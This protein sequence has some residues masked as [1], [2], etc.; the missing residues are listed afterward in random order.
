MAF[1]TIEVSFLQR[2]VAERPLVRASGAAATFFCDNHGLGVCIRR[3]IEYQDKHFAAAERLLRLHDLPV[4]PLGPYSTRAD[5]AQ[6]GGLSEKNYS[7][8]PH[9]NSV[10]VKVLGTCY[11][12]GQRLYTPV[13][14]NLVL[15]REQSLL[16]TCKRI[17][18]VENLESFRFL[19]EYSWVN[20]SNVNFLVVYRG[21]KHAPLGD[22]ASVLMNRSEP[23]WA[24]MDFDPAGLAMANALPLGRLEKILLPSPDWIEVAANTARGRELFDT[25]E[26]QYS[27][28]LD[29]SSSPQVK[30]AWTL[31]KR[32]KSGVTQERMRHYQYSNLAKDANS[33]IEQPPI[34]ARQTC[35]T[36]STPTPPQSA[37]CQP[38]PSG[39]SKC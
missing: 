15:T 36:N 5:V 33:T 18:L 7:T 34:N 1:T 4:S 26:A 10:N 24:F 17:M 12:D 22:A 23:I 37:P 6:F 2:L 16:V 14:A 25:Q 28:T 38:N 20:R 31:M 11:L 13:G 19:E 32:L 9:A 29:A 39:Q 30:K 21:D 35:T 8:A 27:A 3:R